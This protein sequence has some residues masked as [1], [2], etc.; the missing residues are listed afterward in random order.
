M[1]PQ[2][3]TDRRVSE[4]AG[5]AI[6]VSV[7]V[8]VTASIGVFVLV[9]D[10]DAGGPPEATFSFRYIE[11]SALMI[12]HDRRETPYPLMLQTG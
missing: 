6:L 12:T 3:R 5:V 7:T 11:S 10:A 9:V 8:L 2:A 4:L 1:G